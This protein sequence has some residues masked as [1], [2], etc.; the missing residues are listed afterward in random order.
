MMV[1]DALTAYIIVISNLDIDQDKYVLFIDEKGFQL[2]AHQS[3]GENI[4]NVNRGYLAKRALSAMRKQGRQGPFGR[5]PSINVFLCFIKC[6]QHPVVNQQ[7]YEYT[8]SCNV[9]FCLWYLFLM[10]YPLI[11]SLLNIF[12]SKSIHHKICKHIHK[13]TMTHLW[14]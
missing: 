7:Q 1:T 3:V 6:I 11:M 9:L 14:I 5:I 10:W 13:K 4:G 2:L 12:G 8:S